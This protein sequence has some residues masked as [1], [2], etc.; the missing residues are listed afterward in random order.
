[1]LFGGIFELLVHSNVLPLLF[2]QRQMMCNHTFLMS[3]VCV[4]LPTAVYCMSVQKSVRLAIINNS[5]YAVLQQKKTHTVTHVM[6]AWSLPVL[7]YL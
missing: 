6:A 5:W 2:L 3:S 4:G 7:L 1:M